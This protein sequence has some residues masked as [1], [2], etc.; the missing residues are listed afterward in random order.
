[1]FIQSLIMSLSYKNTKRIGNNIL[2]HNKRIVLWWS[3]SIVS[4]HKRMSF[5]KANTLIYTHL[6]TY[7][8]FFFVT[9]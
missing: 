4:K 8:Y 5:V 7:I 9:Y 2:L 3:V 1:V 6:K